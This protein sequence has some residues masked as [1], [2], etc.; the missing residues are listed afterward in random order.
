MLQMGF[1]YQART[2][3]HQTCYGRMLVERTDG[4]V[5]MKPL[6]KTYLV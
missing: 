1:M 6:L 5:Q 2:Q 4:W 3:P